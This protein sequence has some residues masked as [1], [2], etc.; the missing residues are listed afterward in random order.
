MTDY[1]LIIIGAGI[2]GAAV[3]RAASYDGYKVCVLEQYPQPA[4]A[5]SCHSSKL[6]HGGLRYLESFQF[7][8]VKE[9]LHERKSLLKIA[10]HLIKLVPF[11]IPVYK[12]NTRPGWLIFIGLCL[13]RL[14]G[15]GKFRKIP[16]SK[17]NQLDGININHLK[18]VYQYYDGQTNDQELT[19]AVLND[20]IQQGAIFKPEH[21]VTH[22]HAQPERIVI[23]ADNSTT[24]SCKILI[25]ASGPWVNKILEQTTP[26]IDELPIDLVQGTHI[27]LP[28][29]LHKGIYYIEAS[30]KRVVFAIPWQKHCLVGTTETI[31]DQLVENCQPL[32]D[33]IDYLLTVWNQTFNDGLQAA[34]I[35]ESFAGLRVLPTSDDSAF[36]RKR[37]TNLHHPNPKI[38]SIVG[39]KLTAHRATAESVMKL[40]HKQLP[41]YKF[42]DTSNITL[43]T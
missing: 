3:A 22:I 30:D 20:A 14:L 2:H 13:Y 43:N 29:Q 42:S 10:P 11:Y 16:S 15:G 40:V 23:Q 21:K 32:A 9:C 12:H 33:E 41:G 36:R 31:F 24:L 8:L 25:N 7:S 35:I 28:R 6:I 27:V 19:R 17:W 39:G 18:S 37:D 4:L 5:T 26:A 38:I 34:D 1:D